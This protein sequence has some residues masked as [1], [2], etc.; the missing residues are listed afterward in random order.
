M[1]WIA[2]AVIIAIA[3]LLKTYNPLE[4]IGII[5]VFIGIALLVLAGYVVVRATVSVRD[6][7][8]KK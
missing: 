6:L 8:W 4:I 7:E 2:S 3:I 5:V 1:K